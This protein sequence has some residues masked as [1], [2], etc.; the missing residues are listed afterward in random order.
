M[1][2]HESE[3]ARIRLFFPPITII[4][5]CLPLLFKMIPRNRWYGVRVREAYASEGAWY[6]INQIGAVALIVA[7]LVWFVAAIYVPAKYV[8]AIGLSLILLTLGLMT[9][10]QGWT[11]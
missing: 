4:L 9:V 7:S 6:A 1:T 10:L 5:T 3:R 11:L 2:T 8:P